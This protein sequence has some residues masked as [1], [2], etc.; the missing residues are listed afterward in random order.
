MPGNVRIKK[1]RNLVA[2]NVAKKAITRQIVLMLEKVKLKKIL[3]T[4]GTIF[5]MGVGWSDT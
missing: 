5:T 1:R 3:T 4:G 2:S